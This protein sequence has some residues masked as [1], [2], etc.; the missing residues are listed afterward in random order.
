MMLWFFGMGLFLFHLSLV[1]FYKRG[2]VPKH[3][4]WLSFSVVLIYGGVVLVP[5]NN[6]WTMK[7]ITLS[8]ILILLASIAAAFAHRDGDRIRLHCD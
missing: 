5:E 1:A 2:R 7:H 3:F 6:G 4:A 8:A